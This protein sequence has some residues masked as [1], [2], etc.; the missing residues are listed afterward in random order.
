MTISERI[1]GI[2]TDIN[3][4][5]YDKECELKLA[6]L[7]AIA[8]ESILLLGPP[9]VAKSMIARSIK[10]VFRD[11][12]SFEYLM[13]RFS[14]PDEVFGPVSIA[15]L[16]DSEQYERITEGYLPNADV[17]FLDEIWKAGPAIQNS[18]LTV[19]NEKI[20]RNGSR[21]MRLPLK[22]LIAA[23]NELPAQGEGLEALW[24]RFLI[25]VV[26]KSIRNEEDFYRMLLDDSD[27]GGNVHFPISQEEYDQWQKGIDKV[28]ISEDILKTISFIRQKLSDVI[29]DDSDLRK[30]IYV[31]DRRW[32]KIVRLLKTEAYMH[33]RD[34]VEMSDLY[35]I[36]HCLWNNPNE[37]T[38]VK[39]IVLEALAFP[40]ES[41]VGELKKKLEDDL[42]AFHLRDAM[43]KVL[44]RDCDKRLKIYDNGY[45]YVKNHDRGNT[46]IYVYDY[47][48]LSFEWTEAKSAMIFPA[49]NES[50]KLLIHGVEGVG[51]DV[52]DR[53]DIV[54]KLDCRLFR[55]EGCVFI[56]GVR[57]DLEQTEEEEQATNILVEMRYSDTDYIT[58][59]GTVEKEM[60][61]LEKSLDD[62]LFI[63]RNEVRVSQTELVKLKKVLERMK[64]DYLKLQ[65]P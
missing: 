63:A 48:D 9:G 42:K 50:N 5:V 17:V 61:A 58:E 32:K 37:Y 12:N 30:S 45:Y 36:H 20:F 38:D 24:D 22:L 21:E 13:S 14:T 31:S 52:T 19:L 28:K 60:A 35:I 1:S 55:G 65:Q 25:R 3:K 40:I 64:V 18:L 27:I 8:G 59:F 4:G 51:A 56:N 6:L 39:D 46:F 41:H 33:G 62:N 43:E 53:S 29:V 54:G 44:Y 47:L 11:A 10:N 23:S 2:I 57:Y 34:K 7:A 26:S 49:A 16:K 15:K